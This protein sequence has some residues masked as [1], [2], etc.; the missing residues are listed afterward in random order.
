MITRK[1][2]SLLRGQATPFQIVTAC[3]L[4][5]MLGFAPALQQ[6]PGLYVIL[7]VTLLV[8]NA[9]I[10]LA[11][12]V[13]GAGRVLSWGLASTSFAVG[14]FLLDGPT[15]ALADSVVHAP[16]IAWCGLSYYAVAGGQLIGLVLG[17]V[18]GL[19]MAR[20]I[21]AFRK[22]MAAAEGNESRLAAIMSKRWARLAVWLFLGGKG[23]KSWEEKMAA[24][25]VRPVRFAGVGVVAV[26][27]GGAWFGQK[28]LTGEFAHD[29]LALKLET[30]NGATVDLGAVHFDLG[31]GVF[32]VEDL[33][34][35]DRED[36]GR[37]LFRADEIMLDIDQVDLL[38]RRVHVTR[39]VVSEASTGELRSIPGVLVGEPEAALDDEATAEPSPEEGG[40]WTLDEILVEAETW[41][42]RL[43]QADRWL[44]RLSGDA[45]DDCVTL[46]CGS[47]EQPE[48]R[49]ER[50]VRESGWFAL[51]SER[52]AKPAPAFH[53]SELVVEG[54][55]ADWMPGA[56]FDLRGSELSTEPWLV[57][58]PPTVSL[59]SRDGLV[60]FAANLAPASRAGGLGGLRF[61]WKGQDV[62]RAMSMLS[63]DEDA[64]LRG[65]T[66]DLELEGSWANGEIGALDM[67]LRVT[68]RGSTLTIPGVEGAVLD[69][70]V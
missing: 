33:A 18:L 10:G 23:K 67:P 39:L 27:L 17:L 61:H 24:R 34:L 60:A 62:D 29:S 14:E 56:V 36:L 12:L 51:E 48:A 66:L 26:L 40:A 8:T 2:G 11:L 42:T 20:T 52:L 15:A 44:E 41:K 9:N 55:A 28:A 68:F 1:I 57:D 22:R 63:L 58:G 70:F 64:P 50:I 69:E 3:V 53:V 5:A 21:T 47:K 25:R 59:A 16:V 38:R 65:G 19:G 13:A 37:D 45:E 54:I 49:A 46:P 30:M 6:A 32:G 31:A 7:L 35:A 4:G 43:A